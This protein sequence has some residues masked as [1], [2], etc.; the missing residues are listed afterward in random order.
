MGNLFGSMFGLE[1]AS[2]FA[3]QIDWLI[4]LVF[5]ITGAWLLLAEGIFFYFIFKFRKKDGVK[6]QYISGE[7]HHEAKWI[8]WPH[9]AVI[10]FDMLVIVFAVQAWHE[11]KIKLPEPDLTIRVV[12]Q[13]WAWRFQHPGAD[14]QLGTNDDIYTVD[15][16]HLQNDTT[17]NFLLESDDVMH[18]FSIPAFRFKQDAL[19]GRVI[20]GWFKTT[21]VGDYDLQCAEMCGIGHGIM[22]ARVHVRSSEDHQ[23]WIAEESGG[24][25][26]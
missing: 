1:S 10:G 23:K 13:Q 2:S 7:E 11:V 17:Y 21:K 14:K 12:S 19:P 6:A 15:D 20:T 18:D 3:P 5:V 22:G 24:N 26:G 8:H 16:L 25:N 9:Y 4:M